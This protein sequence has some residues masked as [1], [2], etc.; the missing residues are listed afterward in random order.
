MLAINSSMQLE[1]KEYTEN[2]L[3]YTEVPASYGQYLTRTS[4]YFG[5]DVP[6]Q[7]DLPATQNSD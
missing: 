4:G 6:N 7:L 5:H 3:Y 2:R 1:M